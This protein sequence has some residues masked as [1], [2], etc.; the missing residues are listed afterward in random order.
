MKKE[1]GL[2]KDVAVA[3]GAGAV[4]NLVPFVVAGTVGRAIGNGARGD[5]DLGDSINYGVKAGLVASAIF[6]VANV[7]LNADNIK[8]NYDVRKMNE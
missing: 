7:A 5:I 3:F 1:L 8:H 4:Q 6:G 2:V